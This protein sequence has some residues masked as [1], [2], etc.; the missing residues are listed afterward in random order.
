MTHYNGKLPFIGFCQCYV[1]MVIVIVMMLFVL[2]RACFVDGEEGFSVS[3]KITVESDVKKYKELL[4]TANDNFVSIVHLQER[5]ERID[6]IFPAVLAAIK[7]KSYS[8][9]DSREYNIETLYDILQKETAGIKDE[10]DFRSIRSK[11]IADYEK[12]CEKNLEDVKTKWIL[13]NKVMILELFKIMKNNN[14]VFLHYSGS[15]YFDRPVKSGEVILM[16]S[17][18]R[19]KLKKCPPFSNFTLYQYKD[20]KAIFFE[21]GNLCICP[22]GNYLDKKNYCVYKYSLR[23]GNFNIN[24]YS[25]DFVLNDKCQSLYEFGWLEKENDVL[26]IKDKDMLEAFSM[27]VYLDFGYI[28]KEK[29]SGWDIK[30]IPLKGSYNLAT[31]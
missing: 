27:A 16:S 12:N 11:I 18:N 5:V 6:V 24:F 10:K 26:Y 22:S 2:G 30:A 15:E 1:Y 21:K 3:D 31:Q 20:M 13:N 14:L 9:E 23:K 25:V 17:K 4:E 19:P 7:T 28:L 29:P 8:V